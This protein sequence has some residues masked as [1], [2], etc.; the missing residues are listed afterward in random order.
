MSTDRYS[1]PF[2]GCSLLWS[3][4]AVVAFRVSGTS[5]SVSWSVSV[6]GSARLCLLVENMSFFDECVQFVMKFVL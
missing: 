6:S 4:L 2:G 5:V 3:L 1:K